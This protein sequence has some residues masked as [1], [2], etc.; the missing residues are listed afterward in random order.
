M[1]DELDILPPPRIIE[2]FTLEEIEQRKVD[3]FLAVFK[4][5]TGQDF[6]DLTEASPITRLIH[7]A[8]LE[9]FRLRQQLNERFR[10]RFV[11]FAKGDALIDLMAE[12]GLDPINGE[13][14]LQ[15]QQRI[16]T[17]RTGSSAAG[18]P[19]WYIRKAKEVSPEQIEKIAVDYPDQSH[20]RLSVLAKNETGIPAPELVESVREAVNAP[21]VHPDDHITVEVIGAEPVSLEVHARITLEPDADQTVFDALENHFKNAFKAR[22]DLG[23]D[24]P[25]SWVASKL[26]VAGVYKVEDLGGNYP[27]VKP[28]QVAKLNSFV[29]ELESGRQY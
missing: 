27:T 2:E 23:R 15:R 17:Q 25:W 29:L 28:Y 11:Y 5:L 4:E 21:D 16:I 7:S 14:D 24:M 1:A 26:H 8:A 19:E 18:P 9:E 20:A 6:T 22:R 10:N 12:E 13:T 3:T